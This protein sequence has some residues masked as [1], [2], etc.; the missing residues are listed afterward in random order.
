[1]DSIKRITEDS[2]LKLRIRV[3]S[4]QRIRANSGGIRIRANSCEFEPAFLPGTALPGP[5]P[6]TAR[7]A[8]AT[9][10]RGGGARKPRERA[11]THTQQA[12]GADL[13]GDR[14]EPAE[15]TDRMEW[16]TSRRGDGTAGRDDPPHA[17]RR[18]RGKGGGQE[19]DLGTGTRPNPPDLLRAPRTHDQ[20]TAP[21]RAVVAHSATHQPHG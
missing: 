3:R 9:R 11:R 20:G 1:M 18:A 19:K 10:T 16:R 5:Y 12:R 15:R 4:G 7:G 21:A 17:P 13:E 8:C 14:I 2:N 6:G